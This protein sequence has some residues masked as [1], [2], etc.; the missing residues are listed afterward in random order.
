MT[1]IYNRMPSEHARLV[2]EVG[3]PRSAPELTVLDDR[4]LPAVPDFHCP[5]GLCCPGCGKEN[6]TIAR[7]TVRCDACGVSYPLS[8][9]VPDFTCAPDFY[10]GE[11]DRSAMC[12]LLA[13]K[14]RL[15]DTLQEMLRT[16][17]P[18]LRDYL[19]HYATNRCRAGWKF[20]MPFPAGGRVLDMGC[21]WGELGISMAETGAEVVMVDGVPERVAVAVRRAHERGLTRVSGCAALGTTRLPFKDGT[22]DLVVLNGV[23]EWIPVAGQGDPVENQAHLLREISR[24][25]RPHGCVYIGIENRYGASYFRGRREEHTKLRFISLL[26]RVLG[27]IYHRL[28]TGKPYRALTHSG[29]KLHCLLDDVGFSCRKSYYPYPD[30]R[31]FVSVVDLSDQRWIRNSFHPQSVLGRI[32]FFI[33]RRTN[34]MKIFANSFGIVGCKG[35][36]QS[37][38]VTR[39]L[40]ED[41]WFARSG[42]KVLVVAYDVNPNAMAQLV[43]CDG[44][45]EYLLCIPLDQKAIRRMRMRIDRRLALLASM[46]GGEMTPCIESAFHCGEQEGIPYSFEA[47]CREYRASMMLRRKPR[48]K[49]LVK[50]NCVEWLVSFQQDTLKHRQGLPEDVLGQDYQQLLS[51]FFPECV[52]RYQTVLDCLFTD[53]VAI[54]R[55]HG[56]FRFQNVLVDRR[57]Q[58]AKVIDFEFSLP[59]GLPLWDVL[60][61]YFGDAFERQGKWSAAFALLI[62]EFMQWR[63]SPPLC[64]YMEMMKLTQRD[65]L[66]AL[67]TLPLLHLRQKREVEALD[68]SIIVQGLEPVLMSLFRQVEN[69]SAVQE[70]LRVHKLNG[71]R[72]E[73]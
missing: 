33:S 30:Y 14:G 35:V 59:V 4:C 49:A 1:L 46:R 12:E 61:L 65:L 24:V 71:G 26:P 39:L 57:G 44:L 29:H 19:W 67:V 45:D 9:Q 25:L 63:H 32:Q 64:S 56:D 20:L 13:S 2:P 15:D 37:S 53:P 3:Q 52:E 10:W 68:S 23:L 50:K 17:F 21:G 40:L 28:A 34:I 72:S 6:L 22:F 18:G 54:S 73:V 47:Y 5:P 11:L 41:S 66:T 69:D 62:E 48:L 58:I 43:V 27:G 42:K 16:R 7:G 60:T 70:S 55:L 51:A 36:P 38:F 31:E 8:H